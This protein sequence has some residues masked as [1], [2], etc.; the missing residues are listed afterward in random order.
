HESPAA[1]QSQPLSQTAFSTSL[2]AY[3]QVHH[4]EWLAAQK[5]WENCTMDEWK[6]G[7]TELVAEFTKVMDMVKEFMIKRME[8]Y[9]GINKD[10]D[11]HKTRLDA[12]DAMLAQEK[13]RLVKQA[14]GLAGSFVVN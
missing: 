14:G 4:D 6:N 7:P 9:A 8:V 1:T 13:Q 3:I 5:R 11:A 10:V 12:R 2:D